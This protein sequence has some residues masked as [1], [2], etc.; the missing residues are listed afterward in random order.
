M[1]VLVTG[2]SGQVGKFLQEIMPDAIYL[3]SKDCDLRDYSQT[4]SLFK[5]VKP[6][7]V[8]HLAARVG[9][10]MDNIKFPAD[11]FD[12]NISMNTNTLRAA[13]ESGCKKMIAMLSTC[14]YPDKVKK[15]PL[16]E[17][18]LF[19][20]KPNENNFSY[21][22]TKRALACQINAYNKQHN[23]KYSYLIPCNL[24]SEKTNFDEGTAHFVN[25]LINKIH[26][27]KVTKKDSILL[28]GDGTPLRQFM[29]AGDLARVISVCVLEDIYENM[30]IATPENLTIRKI[31]E[32][33]LKACDAEHLK[34]NF[35]TT[36]TNGQHRKD[37]SI[38]E[39]N[40]HI[41][42]FVFTSL[43]EGIKKTYNF[44]L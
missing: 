36:K 38:E 16:K 20:G 30:N 22:I 6:D 5:K 2:G 19:N 4:L 43:S 35:D 24:Y 25:A 27:A 34:I 1:K 29:Y 8:I 14:V 23:T 41:P 37:V 31:A 11:Y 17:K 18:D 13:K 10:I 28:F 32:I 12:D 15:Y 3:S 33:A 9:G 26:M 44:L 39:M 42:D 7:V 40:K 21:A